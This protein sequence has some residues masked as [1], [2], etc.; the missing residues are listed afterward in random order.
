MT[1]RPNTPEPSERARANARRASAAFPVREPPSAVATEVI[2]PRL[3]FVPLDREPQDGDVVVANR[4]WVVHPERGLV[5]FQRTSYQCNDNE[6]IARR[7]GSIYPWATIQFVEI[8]HVP[9]N[10]HDFI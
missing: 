8:A 6:Q 5:I 10:C 3:S 4:W 2:D 9:H 1:S 7:V